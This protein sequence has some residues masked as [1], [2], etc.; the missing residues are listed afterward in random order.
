MLRETVGLVVG[1]LPVEDRARARGAAAFAE[2]R[3]LFGDRVRPVDEGR[4]GGREFDEAGVVAALVERG[5]RVEQRADLLGRVVIFRV[6]EVVADE[7]RVAVVAGLLRLVDLVVTAG[8]AGAVDARVGAD[9][10]PVDVA[11]LRVDAQA[12]R[13]ARTH[14]ED[15][16]TGLGRAGLEEV[17][18]RDA[19]GR[20]VMHADAVHLADEGV[21]VGGSALAVPRLLAGALVERSVTLAVAERTG[22]VAGREIQAAIRAELQRRAVVAA[23]QALLFV[24]Q[25]E[26]LAAGDELVVLHLEAGEILPFET[27]GRVDQVD[28]TVL[29]ELRVEGE[30]EEAV[31]LRLEDLHLGD[32][33]HALGLRVVDLEGAGIF[34]EPEAAVGGELEVHR[35]RQAGEQRLGLEADVLRQGVGG[36]GGRR[37]GQQGGAEEG[38]ETDGGGSHERVT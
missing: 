11:G 34:V 16:G 25:D 9:F 30:G 14:R 15:L 1:L 5:L 28:P 26:L 20:V 27:D 35:L 32:E 4:D 23:L 10:A 36:A 38:E 8:A 31:L 19:V 21:G 18:F 13:I 29:R 33:L 24:F 2:F 22:V 6:R 37:G 3:P 7:E 17:A 12:P